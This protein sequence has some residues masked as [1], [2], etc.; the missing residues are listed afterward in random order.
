VL[1][2][3]V[4]NEFSMCIDVTI[5]LRNLVYNSSLKLEC[6]SKS[7]LFGFY[8]PCPSKSKELEIVFKF[9]GVE[10]KIIVDDEDALELPDE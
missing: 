4:G 1:S 3:S 5:P 6:D 8:D 10:S 2:D 7:Q 9:K